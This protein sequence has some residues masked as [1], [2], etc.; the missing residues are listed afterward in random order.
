MSSKVK[1]LTPKCLQLKLYFMQV[2]GGLVGFVDQHE[3]TLCSICILS[4]PLNSSM[5][6]TCSYRAVE[7]KM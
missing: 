6:C 5:L 3:Q 1:A 2:G 7:H 4:I